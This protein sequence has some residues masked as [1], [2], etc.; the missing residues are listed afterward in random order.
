MYKNTCQCTYM[1]T[2]F[3]VVFSK[4]RLSF[5]G[6]NTQKG[7]FYAIYEDFAIFPIF[8]FCP[9]WALQKSVLRSFLAF[10][11]KI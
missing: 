3:Q 5:A 1:C 4:K 7:H 2:K 11:T 8:N 10:V 6:L 9:I